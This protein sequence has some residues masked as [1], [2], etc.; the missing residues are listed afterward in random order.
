MVTIED[1][2]TILNDIKYV[3]EY[4]IELFLF[5]YCTKYQKID[6]Y[7]VV[8]TCLC[9]HHLSLSPSILFSSLNLFQLTAFSLFWEKN[10]N[11]G[12]KTEISIPFFLFR[13][14]IIFLYCGFVSSIL[15]F[16]LF[17]FNLTFSLK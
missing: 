11:R 1:F 13:I 16:L 9:A 2:A 8:V 4:S 3:F 6:A 17:A 7:F 12:G 14:N 10:V 15:C 5:I